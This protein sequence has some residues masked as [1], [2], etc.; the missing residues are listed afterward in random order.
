MDVK[1]RNGLAMVAE[2]DA[3]IV[4]WRAPASVELWEWNVEE[5][6][7]LAARHPD[8][9][10]FLDLILPSS[11][12]PNA[13]L[14]AIIRADLQ[15]LGP[16]L[17]K[18]VAVPLGDGLWLSVVR[19]IVRGTLLITGQSKQQVVV[20]TLAEGLDRMQEHGSPATPSREVLRVATD[21]LL[22]SLGL[23]Q[24]SAA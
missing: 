23:A 11:N 13:A 7:Q 3:L 2:G 17:R 6:G 8:G 20:A 1:A 22:Q 5:L 19:T 21:A 16:K 4:L 9:V 12:P 15:R 14:R 10:V 18:L 24:T